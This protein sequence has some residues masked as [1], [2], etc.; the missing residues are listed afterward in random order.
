M[1]IALT[2]IACAMLSGGCD[3]VDNRRMPPVPVHI[4]LGNQGLWNTYGVH[5]SGEVR[6]FIRDTNTPDNFPFT[7][8]TY[9][10]F[11][12]VLLIYGLERPLAYDLACPV[13][14]N[15]EVRL[16]VNDSLEAECPKCGSRYDIFSGGGAPIA[17]EAL[18]QKYGLQ[19]Y[20]VIP[21]SLG[22][23]IISR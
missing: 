11:G 6:R 2:G 3:K 23:Y 1:A 20:Q 7:A 13:E 19:T 18:K 17:G 15:K 14:L 10:G 4:D 12:G 8:S 5:G 22:G 21:Q 16:K 9:T